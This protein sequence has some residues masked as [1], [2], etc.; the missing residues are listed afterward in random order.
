MIQRFKRRRHQEEVLATL[1]QIT[2]R[3]SVIERDTAASLRMSSES[4]WAQVFHDTVLTS[5]WLV[6]K[7]FSPGRWAV[8]YPYLYVLY[9]A[10][11]EARPTRILEL[12]MGQSTK[13]ISQYAVAHEDVQH[14]VVEHDQSWVEYCSR[15]LGLPDATE[16]LRCDWGYE[17]H[18]GTEGVRVYSG[19]AE[20]V[21]GR[22]YDLISIDGPLGGDM[23]D[24]ARIDVLR[25]IPDI[26]ADSFVLLVDDCERPGETRMAQEMCELLKKSR[27]KF[28]RGDYQ[29]NKD[30]AVIC[31]VDI[32]FLCSM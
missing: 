27:I 10:L 20:R 9:R 29:G 28:R 26:L 8:G 6:D 23:P 14:S 32:G 22:R 17:S 7:T 25:M 31:S 18:N 30:V 24:Y 15:Q 3:L 21:E 11:D 4:V 1:E 5:R 13:M 12:G 16:I 2:D 19:L